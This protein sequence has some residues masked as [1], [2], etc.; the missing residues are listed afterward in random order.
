MEKFQMVIDWLMAN[1]V[2]LVTLLLAI[3]EVLALIPQLKANSI[4]QA[5]FNGIKWLY[6]WATKPKAE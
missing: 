2:V 5:I 3:S 1:K 4:A 6:G